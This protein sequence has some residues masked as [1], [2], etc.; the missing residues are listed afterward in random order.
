[1]AEREKEELLRVFATSEIKKLLDA[2]THV[3]RIIE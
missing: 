1:M 3:N 2:E